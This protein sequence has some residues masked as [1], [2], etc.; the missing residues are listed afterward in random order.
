[1]PDHDTLFGFVPPAAAPKPPRKPRISTFIVAGITALFMLLGA[2]SGGVG[3]ALVFLGIS[4]ALT[5]LY[6]LLTGRRSWAWLPAQRKAGAIAIA[7]SLALFIGGAVALPH[8]A[9]AD[10]EAASSESAAKVASAKA[11]P[12]A[13]ATAS[14]SSTPTPTADSTGEPLDPENPAVLAAGVTATAPNAQPAYATKA[15]D[16]LATLSIKGRAPKTGY[17]RAQFGQ[18]WLDVDRNGCD[19]RND[20][21]RRDLTGITYTNSVP[22]KV[23]T[24]TLADPYTGK[25]ISF[26]RGSGTSTAVQID[27]VVALSDAWQKGAQQ[28]TTEQRTAFANDPLNL[29]A[30][31]GPTNQQKGDGDAATWLPPNKPF[32]CE[33]VARQIS[34]KATY[35]LWV[36]Q[37]EH[38]AMARILGDCSG[39]LAPTSQQSPAPAPAVAE[40]AP[41]AAA[42]APAAVA[43]APA[44]VAPAPAPVVPAAPAP[45]APAPA[46]AAP[47]PAA[48]YYANCTAARAAGA[49]PLY[50]GQAGYRSALDRDS[51]GIACE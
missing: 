18:A 42:P 43:P 27:H 26:V 50:A 34:V 2:L 48:V 21:L 14:P 23:Q 5:G 7:A 24:G 31:D 41:A 32:R 3:G 20:I 33:Y 19:T 11:S 30:T 47:A 13:T 44:P 28:L 36:T 17:D 16:L 22:C 49:A 37:A 6:V 35:G 12:T 25:T 9:S 10:L 4:T 15:V 29:Q 38:D 8:V 40:P 1:M 45:A 46:P 51:D 39:Q